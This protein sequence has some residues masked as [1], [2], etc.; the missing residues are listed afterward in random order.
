MQWDQKII[1]N[2]ISVSSDLLCVIDEVGKYVYVSASSKEIL[3]YAPEE[4]LEKHFIDFVAPNDKAL[5][6]ETHET[7]FNGTPIKNFYNHY[8]HKSG[9]TVPLS[10]SAV[11]SEEERVIYCLGRDAADLRL[12]QQKLAQKDEFHST[13]L[14]HGSDMLGLLNE[15][16][17]YIYVGGAV[18]R[19]LN[20]EP[21]QL[22]GCN[23]FDLIHPDDV[24]LAGEALAKIL[25]QEV[26][27][28]PD[29]RF[30]NAHGEWRWIE[31]IVSNQL[32]NPSVNAL[33]VS[34]RDI[35]ERKEASLRLAESEYRFR[36]LFENNPDNATY[37]NREGVILDAN[38]TFLSCV[39]LPLEEVVSKKIIDFLPPEV[40]PLC[41]ENLE[42]AFRGEKINFTIE[43][44]K[45]NDKVV[46]LNITKIP[47]VVNGEVIGVHS[48]AKDVTEV[49]VAHTIIEKQ[50]ETLQTIFESITDAFFMLGKDWR[51]KLV[52]GE[53]ERVLGL[54][55]D[56]CLG[57]TIWEVFPELIN[58]EFYKY[59][60]QAISTGQAVKFES[61]LQLSKIWL[62][63]KA[64]PSEEG[65]SVYFSD[66]TE[67]VLA[68]EE[69]EKL[70][71][72]ASKI[73]NGVI[74]TTPKG[75]IEW[76][77][78]AF[79][80]NTGYTFDEAKGQN[81]AT[82][83]EGLETDQEKG[84]EIT[85][86]LKKGIPFNIMVLH[87][88]KSGEKVWIS[89]DFTPILTDDGQV[90]QHIVIQ[91][92]ITF[93]KAAEERHLEMTRDLYRQNR[94]L[95]QFTYIVSHNL[96]APVAN[97]MGLA[98]FLTKLDKQSAMYDTSLA[99]LKTSVFKLDTV[100]RDLNMILSL[101][102]QQDILEREMVTLADVFEQVRLYFMESLAHHKGE[103]VAD[104][105]PDV[106]IKT[107]RAYLYSIFY[108]LLS[109]AIKYRSEA[110]TLR[111]EIS[112][113][114]CSSGGLEIHFADN[115]SGFDMEKAGNNVFKLYK[116]FHNNKKGRGMGLFLVKT[117]VESMGGTIEMKSKLNEGTRVEIHIPGEIAAN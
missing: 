73:S 103:I 50:A 99:H 56:E 31:A 6:W 8:L 17:E 59:Y 69:R 65:L 3:G 85:E 52:N 78:N 100:L 113:Q 40:G 117:H 32:E 38:P 9:T 81:L 7:V 20:Y 53:F 25:R 42:R 112:C 105:S 96:R 21:G 76:V 51:F 61:F 82:F 84:Q 62:E 29:L 95:Q 28:V 19:L 54:K 57:K 47:V 109:N 114:V 2:L 67:N 111:V 24:P 27:Q 23:V 71:L 44:P 101:R 91:K 5:T 36:S 88:K 39:G 46:R 94:D 13:L 83:L 90:S 75:K 87:Y 92:D 110:R 48:I 107:N 66:I 18:S 104:I 4:L 98:D 102:D 116:R 70:S 77:N 16:G 74:I 108:N 80:R 72:V 14:Q 15:V 22:I 30:K 12:A 34:S 45:P 58:G 49:S 79:T 64:F 11:W 37:E 55:R 89:M 97:A 68:Q 26:V 35:T 93:R 33:V 10:W 86:K 1:E 106:K 115:G 63:V 60:K 43:I 41:D